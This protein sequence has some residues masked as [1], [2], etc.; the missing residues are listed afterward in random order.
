MNH[1][2]HEGVNSAE[3]IRKYVSSA[4]LANLHISTFELSED[5][6]WCDVCLSEYSQVLLDALR[7]GKIGVAVNL[8]RRRSFMQDYVDLGFFY[9]S[10]LE[11]TWVLLNRIAGAPADA[12]SE[13]NRAVDRYNVLFL[14][15]LEKPAISEGK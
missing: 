4:N 15:W 12:S 6:A 8:T 13:Q 9:A 1:P 7:S 11:E 3:R 10:S 14:D 5:L 2:A